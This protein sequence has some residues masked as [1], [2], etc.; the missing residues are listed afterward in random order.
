MFEMIKKETELIHGISSELN[1]LKIFLV[2]N[3]VESS[4]LSTVESPN[5][6]QDDIR[7]NVSNLDYIYKQVKEIGDVIRGERKNGTN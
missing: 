6:L 1:D 5:C 4:E 3:K 2:G 7:N